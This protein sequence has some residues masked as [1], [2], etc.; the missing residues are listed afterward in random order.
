MC[1]YVVR[2]ERRRGVA[3]LLFGNPN[4]LSEKKS[5]RVTVSILWSS[6]DVS[7]Y[8]LSHNVYKTKYKLTTY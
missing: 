2:L 5:E 1:I 7:G 8:V 3:L 6:V 4:G